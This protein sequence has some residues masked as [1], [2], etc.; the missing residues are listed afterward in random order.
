MNLGP[1]LPKAH[2]PSAVPGG[3]SQVILPM[4]LR[5]TPGPVHARWGGEL[6][7]PRLSLRPTQKE[8]RGRGWTR[9]AETGSFCSRV[10]TEHVP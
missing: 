7:S 6:W 9:A 3:A 4:R 2:L 10:S 5:G 8:R 1:S